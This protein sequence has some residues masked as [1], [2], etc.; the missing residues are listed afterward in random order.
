[1]TS[2]LNLSFDRPRSK[3]SPI[4]DVLRDRGMKSV[5]SK[6]PEAYKRK[7]IE[8]IEGFNRGRSFTVEDVREIVGDPPEEA[9]YNCFGA[10]TRSAAC[11][12]LMRKTGMFVNAKRASLHSSQLAVWVRL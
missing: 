8:A 12:G 1:M 2:Q 11:R 3:E 9:H 7:F 5:L 4:G 6:T 10:L